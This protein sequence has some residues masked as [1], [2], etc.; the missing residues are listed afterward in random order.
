[1]SQAGRT[2]AAAGRVR[3]PIEK[4][5]PLSVAEFK[6][7]PPK[8]RIKPW[9]FEVDMQKE[10]GSVIPYTFDLYLGSLSAPGGALF[11]ATTPSEKI[12]RDEETAARNKELAA[13]FKKQAAKDRKQAVELRKKAD[14]LERE[15]AFHRKK[16]KESR[17]LAKKI[18]HSDVND[19]DK[20]EVV[21]DRIY[22]AEV[23]ERAALRAEGLAQQYDKEARELEEAAEKS[24]KRVQEL[25]A[26]K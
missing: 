13:L 22:E 23:D 19:P 11:D 9:L 12:A 10:D 1:M 17:D 25:E 14:K 15:A 21:E 26:I 8:N 24:E 7:Q 18:A 16:E 4:S 2:Q 3:Q 5:I 20:V 6:C